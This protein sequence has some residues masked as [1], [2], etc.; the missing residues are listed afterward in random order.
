MVVC[1]LGYVLYFCRGKLAGS[2]ADRIIFIAAIKSF[3]LIINCT[4]MY[5]MSAMTEN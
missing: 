1:V 2:E 5:I 3:C 4:S